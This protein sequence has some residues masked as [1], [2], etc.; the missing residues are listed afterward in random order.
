[1]PFVRISVDSSRSPAEISAISEGVYEALREAIQAPKDDKFHVVTSHSPQELIFSPDYL[2]IQRSEHFLAIQIYFY[3]GRTVEQKK[4][5]YKT[6]ADKLAIN[7]GI[8]KEDIF[9]LLIDTPRENW[10][11]GNGEAQFAPPA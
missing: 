7:P 4:L 1:M 8:R 3:A 9:I 10:S 2:G 6:I 11:Y 5:I